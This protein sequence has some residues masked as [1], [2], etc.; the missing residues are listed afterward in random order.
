M[1]GRFTQC[2]TWREIH[3]IYA[4]VGPARNIEPR[5][6]IEPTATIHTVAAPLAVGNTL[7]T[8]RWGLIPAWWSK[9]ASD[10]PPTFNVHA[11]RLTEPIFLSAFKR[12]RCI[13]PASGYFEWKATPDGKEPYYISAADGG[14]LSIAGVFDEWNDTET[15]DIVWSCSMIIT[16]ANEFTRPVHNRMPALLR[17]K[18]FEPWLSGTAGAEVLKPADE[19]YL[20]MWPVSARIIQ[21]GGGDD[22]TLITAV[23]SD[24][25][26]R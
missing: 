21:S 8:M 20:R 4:L 22:P 23:T 7:V 17:E 9:A 12:N 11:R 19:D 24:A 26:R 1:T 14:V 15:G 13:I 6:N 3:Q 18:D 25:D 5:Y 10:L 16:A 2:F